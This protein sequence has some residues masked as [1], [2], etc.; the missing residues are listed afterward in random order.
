M[1]DEKMNENKQYED[2]HIFKQINKNALY[3]TNS[4]YAKK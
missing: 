1:L 2:E 4:N 3:E